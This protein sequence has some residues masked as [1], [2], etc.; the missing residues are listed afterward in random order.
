[1]KVKCD[2]CEKS[3]TGNID[4]LM[5]KGWNRAIFRSPIRKTITSCGNGD[6]IAKMQYEIESILKH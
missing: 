3:A 5:E 2:F 6:H 4:E 1:M